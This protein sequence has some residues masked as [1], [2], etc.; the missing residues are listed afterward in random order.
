MVSSGFEYGPMTEHCEHYNEATGYI[1]T[2][3]CK[4]DGRLAGCYEGI[5]SALL[6]W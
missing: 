3:N 4:L 1:Q 5:L 6:C 2:G